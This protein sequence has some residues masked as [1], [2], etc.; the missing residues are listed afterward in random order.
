MKYRILTPLEWKILE[1]YL[2]NETKLDGL[3]VLLHRGQ[4][5]ITDLTQDHQLLEAALRNAGKTKRLRV[6]P[7][8]KPLGKLI[9]LAKPEVGKTPPAGPSLAIQP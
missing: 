3:S 4:K 5:S 1:A 7:A 8:N 9:E 6:Q 2:N